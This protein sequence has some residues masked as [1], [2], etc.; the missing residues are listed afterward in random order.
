M[1]GCPVCPA[2]GYDVDDD[3]PCCGEAYHACEDHDVPV[4]WVPE[5][6]ERLDGRARCV[7]GRPN[8]TALRAASAGRGPAS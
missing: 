4:V 2:G 3:L 1:N 8:S 6:G 7:C 5:T